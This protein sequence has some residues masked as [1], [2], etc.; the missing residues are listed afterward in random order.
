[1]YHYIFDSE[2]TDKINS[3]VDHCEH[4]ALYPSQ[5]K[6]R[7]YAWSSLLVD[8]FIKPQYSMS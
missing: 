5:T 1:M 6:I 8:I 4:F 3:C 2:Y 7:M